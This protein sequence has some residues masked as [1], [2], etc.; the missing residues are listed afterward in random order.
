MHDNPTLPE[1]EF[2]SSAPGYW[3]DKNISPADWNSAAWQ[4]RN[5]ITTLKQ[6]EEHLT[7]TEEER[8]GVLLSGNKLAMAITPHYFNLMD[9]ERSRLPHPPAGHPAHRGNLGRSR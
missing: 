4:L 9:A 3:S 5:R 7:L 8:A 2:R 1:K 6:L